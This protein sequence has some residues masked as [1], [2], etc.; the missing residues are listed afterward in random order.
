M[1]LSEEA[2]KPHELLHVMLEP[3]DLVELA[4]VSQTNRQLAACVRSLVSA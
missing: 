3:F 2:L 1:Q 4:R